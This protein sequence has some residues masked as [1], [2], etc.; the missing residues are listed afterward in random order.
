M[1]SSLYVGDLTADTRECNLFEPFNA[2]GPVRG[3][4]VVRDE[5]TRKS[6]GY[7]YVIFWRVEDAITALKESQH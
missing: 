6:L 4:R 7:A 3:I 5:I 2:I 1:A